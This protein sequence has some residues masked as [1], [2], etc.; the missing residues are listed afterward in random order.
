MKIYLVNQQPFSIQIQSKNIS[1]FGDKYFAGLK[2]L[3]STQVEGDKLFF[4]LSIF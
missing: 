2:L 1:F 3:F 4:W